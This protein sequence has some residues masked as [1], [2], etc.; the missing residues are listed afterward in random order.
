[1]TN[2]IF[3]P[4]D[5][6]V[7]GL[8]AENYVYCTGVLIGPRA[9]L[10]AA[11][12]IRAGRPETI[13]FEAK[14]Q[15]PKVL[16]VLK[17]W[18]HPRYGSE[19]PNFDV[20]MLLSGESAQAPW[21]TLPAPP[22]AKLEVGTEVRI[23]GYGQTEISDDSAPKRQQGTAIV[24]G[25]SPATFSLGASPSLACAGDSGGPVFA[26]IAGAEALVG[27]VSHGDE[28]CS[29]RT[30]VVR[31]EVHFATFL[32]P[33]LADLTRSSAVFG[34]RCYDANN[35]ASGLCLRPDDAPDFGYCSQAC[36]TASDCLAGTDCE[37]DGAGPRACRLPLPS[38]A[39]LGSRCTSN[40]ECQDGLCASPDRASP[41]M[42]SKLCFSDDALT[43][44]S[45]SVCAP[46]A[47]E[48]RI[49]GC[50]PKP[51]APADTDMKCAVSRFP[52][53]SGQSLLELAGLVGIVALRGARRR[54]PR[55][56]RG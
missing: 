53:R 33:L 2:S 23:V 56:P 13:V 28:A 24:T 32:G 21:V 47:E 31:P 48:S 38:P 40:A 49:R 50:F 9:V 36:V 34:E 10:T 6:A 7:V 39:A 52:P 27:V 55:E 29:E 46:T 44:A 25:S 42:C 35:C 51:R 45:G 43:C 14:G 54:V 41:R 3:A 18:Q 30:E 1:M 16:P 8:A 22:S 15:S 26:T 5:G 17:S 12:C 11:H 4:R 37:A 20:G 19:G